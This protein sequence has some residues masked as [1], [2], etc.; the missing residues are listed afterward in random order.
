MRKIVHMLFGALAVLAVTATGASA[1][2]VQ[3]W[4]TQDQ[5]IHETFAMPFFTTISAPVTLQVDDLLHNAP[6]IEHVNFVDLQDQGTTISK[7]SVSVWG[8]GSP[9][10]RFSATVTIDPAKFAHSG[11]QEVRVRSNIDKPDREFPTTRL[12]LF[13]NN[14]KSRSDYCGGPGVQGR[15]GGGAW[16]P[17][18]PSNYRIIFIDCRDVALTQTR[19]LFAGDKIRVK[20]QDGGLFCN[21]DPHFHAGDPGIVLLANG[22]ANTWT[23]LTIPGG[24]APGAH[25]LH[26][27]SQTGVE[28]GA[29]VLD[30]RAGVP[31]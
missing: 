1:F 8:D 18:I 25:K 15:C 16:Y 10:Q 11:W 23:T 19:D 13:I 27:R 7:A 14:G 21:V 2:E 31:V 6:T 28:A 29:F 17:D 30:F 22:A 12:C 26:C 4:K 9:E 20:A 3:G 5:H 24:L